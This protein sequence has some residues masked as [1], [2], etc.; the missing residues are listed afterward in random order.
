MSV[1]AIVLWCAIGVSILLALILVPLSVTAESPCCGAD[2]SAVPLI[3]NRSFEALADMQLAKNA[4]DDTAPRFDA[5]ALIQRINSAKHAPTVY[6]LTGQVKQ[7]ITRVLPKLQAP[8]VLITG[9][10]DAD[11][12]PDVDAKWLD[13]PYVKA[14]WAQNLVTDHAKARALPIGVDFHSLSGSGLKHTVAWGEQ[15][16]ADAQCAQLMHLAEQ[17]RQLPRKPVVFC[18]FWIASN[19][20]VRQPAWDALKDQPFAEM[21]ENGNKRNTVWQCI[22]RARFTLCPAGHGMDTH[23]L[24]EAL[25]LGSIPIIKPY[26]PALMRLL[27]GLP[28]VVVHDWSDICASR[29]QTW[30]AEHGPALDAGI[31]AVCT[32][33]HW[34]AAIA[35]SVS[36][37]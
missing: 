30:A 5:N 15:Q 36:K 16:S 20:D 11:A 7:F 9:R 29:M 25:I 37:I 13:S 26:P 8:V 28:I 12:L 2:A 35:Q 34:S 23:R 31:P 4:K 10:S 19:S 1:A 3:W 14:W 22:S 6:L 27:E 24:W 18:N 32:V 21:L 17:A 33:A